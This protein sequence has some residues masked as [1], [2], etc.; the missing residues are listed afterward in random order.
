MA[1]LSTIIARAKAR[2]DMEG[3]S[4]V[5]DGEWAAW[6][7]SEY[8]QLYDFIAQHPEN[9]LYLTSF[10]SQL[11]A[12]QADYTV[13][14]TTGNPIYRI[15]G[16]DIKLSD[17]GYYPMT[18]SGWNDRQENTSVYRHA[19]RHRY[20]YQL[21]GRAT[22]GAPI[23]RINPTPYS[24]DTF[25]VWYTPVAGDI[26]DDNIIELFGWDEYIILGM[27]IRALTKEES[28]TSALRLDKQNEAARINQA[29]Q[30]MNQGGAGAMGSSEYAPYPWEY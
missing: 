24:A 26:S 25:R 15:S 8:K 23:V 1:D 27:A 21:M 11:V 10:E 2:S 18:V 22:T 4:F 14:P 3:S 28:D 30:S 20:A 29:I 19:A 17:G 9:R 7:N 5:D 13:T 12:G 6:A 16:V